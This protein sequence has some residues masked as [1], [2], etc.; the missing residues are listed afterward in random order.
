MTDNT[1]RPN[2]ATPRL[3]RAMSQNLNIHDR[4]YEALSL[5]AILSRIESVET[6]LELNGLHVLAGEV[7]DKL[8]TVMEMLAVQ[9]DMLNPLVPQREEPESEELPLAA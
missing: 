7:E 3:E 9:K 6:R 4:V 5:T 1:P 2:S 8:R